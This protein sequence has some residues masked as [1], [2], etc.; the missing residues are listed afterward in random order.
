MPGR[1]ALAAAAVIM[2]SAA[3]GRQVVG[4]EPTSNTQSAVRRSTGAEPRH[5][6]E[7]S[8]TGPLAL[9]CIGKGKEEIYP[10]PERDTGQVTYDVAYVP[11][12][13]TQVAPGPAAPFCAGDATC[14]TD[15]TAGKLGL[16]VTDVPGRPG[17]SQSFKLDRASGKFIATGGGL[18]GGWSQ[19]GT[20]RP[21]RARSN[22]LDALGRLNN[23]LEAIRSAEA[24]A[25]RSGATLIGSLAD[26]IASAR[27]RVA[28]LFPE[29]AATI[30]AG[31]TD[32]T[33]SRTSHQAAFSAGLL[34]K[35]IVAQLIDLETALH[36]DGA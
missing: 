22:V 19:A 10:F 34:R 23:L 33:C 36:A 12:Q 18:D 21:A 20:C 31:G 27:R 7:R 6:A 3:S 11:M 35:R 28:V 9:L 30:E 32:Y 24:C 26:R 15:V 25:G 1:E 16:V 5:A 29:R 4:P 17:Y 14:R 13:V 8:S 2:L